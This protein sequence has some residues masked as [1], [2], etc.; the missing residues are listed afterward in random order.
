MGELQAYGMGTRRGDTQPIAD[1]NF[2]YYD[3]YMVETTQKSGRSFWIRPLGGV[4]NQK[5]P[6]LFTLDPLVDQYLQGNR[7]RLEMLLRVTMPDGSATRAWQDI[8]APV[9]FLGAAMFEGVEVAL[10]G[11][12]FPGAM[13]INCGYKAYIET[14]LSNDADSRNSHLKSDL[15]YMDTPGEFMNFRVAADALRR[16]FVNG[17][18]DGRIPRPTI[19]P[20]MQAGENSPFADV[21]AVDVI[22]SSGDGYRTAE[23]ETRPEEGQPLSEEEKALRRRNLYRRLYARDMMETHDYLGVTGGQFVNRG[24]DER[25]IVSKGSAL[26]NVHVPITHDVFRMSNHLGPGNRL[27]IK[28]T[29][30]PDSFLLNSHITDEGY[31]LEIVDMRLHLHTITLYES[32]PRP[33]EERYQ[34]SETQFHKQIVAQNSPTITFRLHNGGVMPKTVIVA[35]AC[36]AAVDGAYNYNP[37][38]FHHFFMSEIKLVINGE[39]HPSDGLQTDFTQPNPLI[40][41]AYSWLYENTGCVDGDRG[42]IVSYP[43]FMSGSFIIPFDLTP[44][45]CNSLHNHDAKFGYIDLTVSWA[46]PLPEPIYILYEQVFSRV[47]VNDKLNNKMYLLHMAA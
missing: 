39:T 3:N 4:T 7:T 14:L 31:K 34:I 19:P 30:Y 17:V 25:F 37:W 5:G 6:H 29:R 42:N 28:L 35:M 8:V 45:L 20:I 10:N 9:N 13:Q 27:D 40:S 21:D 43:A 32:V 33:L 22:L 44:D 38:N 11:Q 18:K 12:P 23:A 36:A 2:D 46:I 24:F 47:L 41:R 26:F 15:F 16:A 1:G